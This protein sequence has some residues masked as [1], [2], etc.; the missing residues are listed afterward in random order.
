MLH[1]TACWHGSLEWNEFP[2]STDLSWINTVTA[3]HIEINHRFLW[4]WWRLE[5]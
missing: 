4:K 1:M 2:L 3:G 5:I